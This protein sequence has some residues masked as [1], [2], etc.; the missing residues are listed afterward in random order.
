MNLIKRMVGAKSN[1][2]QEQRLV[3]PVISCAISNIQSNNKTGSDNNMFPFYVAVVACFYCLVERNNIVIVQSFVER[4]SFSY[5][6]IASLESIKSKL[7]SDKL[8]F[9]GSVE[10]RY[11]GLGFGSFIQVNSW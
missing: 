10:L 6:P 1:L 4:P 7:C 8:S 9:I 2:F 3:F 11:W 5:N